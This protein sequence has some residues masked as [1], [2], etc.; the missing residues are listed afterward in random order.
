MHG[1]NGILVG[2][3]VVFLKIQIIHPVFDPVFSSSC[4]KIKFIHVEAFSSS[5][6][7]LTCCWTLCP[8]V[9]YSS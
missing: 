2:N 8:G 4:L 7:L 1:S 3:F 5:I 9:E 6:L